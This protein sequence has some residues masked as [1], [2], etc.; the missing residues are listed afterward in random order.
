MPAHTVCR[1]HRHDRHHEYG[2]HARFAF[3][4]MQEGDD[5]VVPVAHSLRMLAALQAARVGVTYAWFPG[6]DHL[7]WRTWSNETPEALAF[8][9]RH[10]SPER[11]T[12]LTGGG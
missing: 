5:S 4:I 8:L 2:D 6:Y 9:G 7:A 11:T 10:L 12:F 3:R 1:H